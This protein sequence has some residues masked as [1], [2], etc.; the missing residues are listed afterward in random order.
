MRRHVQVRYSKPEVVMTERIKKEQ[1]QQ[2]AKELMDM[3]LKAL[4]KITVP[5]TLAMKEQKLTLRQPKSAEVT[6][7]ANQQVTSL[8]DQHFRG[9]MLENAPKHDQDYILTEKKTW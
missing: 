4:E 5:E 8:T 7:P 6:N 3:F 1:I 9:R 2:E